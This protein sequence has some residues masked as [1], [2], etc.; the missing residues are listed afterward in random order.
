MSKAA[1]IFPGQGSQYPGM[2]KEF[3]ENFPVARQVFEEADDSL[4]FKLSTICF[5]GSDEELRLTANTQPAILTASIAALRVVQQE[6]GLKADYLAGHSLGEYSALVCSGALNF[7]DAVRTV[8]A[9]GTFMQ[10]AVPVGTGSMAAILSVEQ[11]VLEDICREA[12][13]GEVVAPANFNSPG[14]IVIAGAVA[15]VARAIEIAKARGYRKAM[16]LPVSAPFHCALMKPAADRLSKVLDLV[17]ANDML[18]PV[19][20]NANAAPNQDKEMVKPLLVTQVCAP[21]LWDQSINAMVGLGCARFV[22]IGPGKV[23]SGLVKR[24][25]KEVTTA[26][27]EDLASLKSLAD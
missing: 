8:R 9:R 2:G 11:D 16:L 17:A 15:A 6:T 12:A 22:E 21:V 4:G 1:F 24:I 3:A 20:A 10:E 14:Q 27:V 18:L 7:C 13:E 5:S 26:N 19:V 23:L 25:T